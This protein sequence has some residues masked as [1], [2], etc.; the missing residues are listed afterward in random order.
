M[1][2][3]ISSSKIFSTNKKILSV[4][5]IQFIVSIRFIRVLVCH[6]QEL[7]SVTD[8]SFVHYDNYYLLIFI[9]VKILS[10]CLDC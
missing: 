7:D 2:S 5:I 6:I 3:K 8:S 9:N 10:H 1:I 4:D